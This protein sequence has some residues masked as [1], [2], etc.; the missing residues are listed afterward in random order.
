MY[1]H[2]CEYCGAML[3]PGEFCDCRKENNKEEKKEML[4]AEVYSE[5][6]D[7]LTIEDIE[8]LAAQ[9]YRVTIS[10][11][12]IIAVLPEGKELKYDA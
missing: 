4:K 11:G 8:K 1:G 3:D 6:L 12:H 10:N 2:Q 5:W 7:R 9:G